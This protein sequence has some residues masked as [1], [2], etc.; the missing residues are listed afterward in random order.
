[1]IFDGFPT[2]GCIEAGLH[3]VLNC[4][5][6]P[7]AQNI[8]L[9]DGENVVIENDLDRM[10]QRVRGLLA[11]PKELY[12]LGRANL[13]KYQHVFRLSEQLNARTRLIIREMLREGTVPFPDRPVTSGVTIVERRSLGA[14]QAYEKT[15]DRL[16]D[17]AGR[18][19][20][21]IELQLVRIADLRRDVA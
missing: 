9:T 6:D 14:Q 10:S 4:V 8:A 13:H 20:G 12:R 11:D 2:G 16:S 17:K 18:L 3:G 1:G 19:R 7:L 21:T 5:A 15:I